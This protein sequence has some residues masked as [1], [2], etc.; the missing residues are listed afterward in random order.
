MPGSPRSR[1]TTSGWW[2]AASSSA[3]LAG[4]GEVDVVAAGAQVD[5]ER[6]PDRRLVVDDEHA[7]RSLTRSDRR[8]ARTPSSGRRR[9]VSSTVSSPPIASTKPAR[10][11]EPEADARRRCPGRRRAAGTARRSG[12]AG[13]AGRR[14]PWSTT[15]RSTR[16][17]TVLAPRPGP[18]IRPASTRARCRST[19]AT[20]R[21]SSARVGVDPRQRLGHV[22][23][24]PAPRGRRRLAERRGR[25]PPRARGRRSDEVHRA[26]LEPAHVEQVPDER[27]EPVGL[28]V[29]RLE[30]LAGRLG[31]PRRRRAAAG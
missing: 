16:S 1:T 15:R 12:R 14:G 5:A 28:L 30:E 18:S 20:A 29:D 17:P 22:D 25:R 7:R 6:P 21:S 4:L 10:D 26:G 11:R 3:C 24:R 2:R 19:F 13:P 23:A 9:G 31:R 8:E 27:V